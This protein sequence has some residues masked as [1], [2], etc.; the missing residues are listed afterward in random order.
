MTYSVVICD[1]A[2]YYRSMFSLALSLEPDLEMVGEAISGVEA[3]E[4]TRQQE[5]DVLLLDVAV[6]E[7]D[8]IE[9]LLHIRNLDIDTR[10]IMLSG[11]SDPDLKTRALAAGA[12]SYLEK[13]ATPAQITDAILTPYTRHG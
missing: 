10:V 4:L 5:P 7:M 8:G 6:P 3:V 2:V 13:G 12:F 9:A 1:D 11:F